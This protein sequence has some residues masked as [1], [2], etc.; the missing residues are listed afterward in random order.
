MRL[1]A[2][3]TSLTR[4]TYIKPSD[5]GRMEWK[6]SGVWMVSMALPKGGE[7]CTT[8]NKISLEALWI[9]ARVILWAIASVSLAEGRRC[10]EVLQRLR[11]RT[12]QSHNGQ[13]VCISNKDFARA[14]MKSG[15]YF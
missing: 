13:H 14:Q 12:H 8:H 9:S 15:S 11:N 5:L 6:I 1:G 2:S 3:L 7:F 10:Q 4:D